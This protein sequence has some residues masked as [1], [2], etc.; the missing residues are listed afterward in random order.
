MHFLP[1]KI[2]LL[3]M[4]LPKPAVMGLFR[5]LAARFS[6]SQI[7]FE[8]VHEKYTKGFWKKRVESKMRG[9]LGSEAGASY[10]FGVREADEIERYAQGLKVVEEWSYFED[11]DII[12]GLLRLFRHFKFMTRTQWTIRATID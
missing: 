3:L 9:N 11:R 1:S 2:F 8:V 4:Y 5:K 6:K 10:Q 12:P 7:V